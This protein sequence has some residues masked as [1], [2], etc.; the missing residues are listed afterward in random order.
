MTQPALSYLHEREKEK[1]MRTIH[2][3]VTLA[4]ILTTIP[5]MLLASSKLADQKLAQG[6][7][8]CTQQG[9]EFDAG[10]AVQSMDVNGDGSD[11][12]IIDESQFSCST[13]ASLFGG[14]GGSIVTIQIGDVV[15][16]EM[17]QGWEILDRYNQK[18]LL[19]GRHGSFCNQPGYVA[20][21]EAMV[22]SE[23]AWQTVATK[24]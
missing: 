5:S 22:F 13:A 18:I 1:S 14:T 6:K 10:N 20:C 23:G 12:L 15:L 3:A 11:D 4:V 16:Q 9:G 21:F 19:L 17:A 2:V 8:A 7:E 24:D